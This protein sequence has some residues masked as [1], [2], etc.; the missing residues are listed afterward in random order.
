VDVPSVEVV[1]SH[2]LLLFSF[3]QGGVNDLR[4]HVWEAGVVGDACLAIQNQPQVVRVG[5]ATWIDLFNQEA[6]PLPELEAL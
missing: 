2:P 3:F 5:R 6:F 4:V 1:R